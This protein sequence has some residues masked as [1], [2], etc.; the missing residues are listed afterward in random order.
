MDN[1]FT[2]YDAMEK[3][4]VFRAN[5]ANI[6]SRG[7]NGLAIYKKQ[8]YPKML[9]HP[10]GAT[11]VTVPAEVVATAMGPKVLKEHT[12]LINVIVETAD[13]HKRLKAEGWHE[14]PAEAIAAAGVEA[15]TL[16]P[17]EIALEEANRKIAQLEAEAAAREEA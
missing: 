3:K 5:P 17:A 11:R 1:V 12:E 4:G 10:K 7:P 13:E 16:S 15:V 8:N 9:Y 14:T 2:I 6:N